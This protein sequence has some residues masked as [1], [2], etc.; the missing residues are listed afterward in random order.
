M[1]LIIGV[2]TT[3]AKETSHRIGAARL[4]RAA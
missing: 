3:I 1:I 2:A 4:K